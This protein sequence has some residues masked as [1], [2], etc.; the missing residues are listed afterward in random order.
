MRNA[1]SGNVPKKL[2]KRP[3][4]SSRLKNSNASVRRRTP[5]RR[6][7]SNALRRFVRSRLLPKHNAAPNNNVLRRP[8][9]ANRLNK[10]LKKRSGAPRSKKHNKRLSSV[11]K[12]NR[13]LR[14][15]SV[16]LKSRNW[17]RLASVKHSRRSKL[18]RPRNK[19]NAECLISRRVRND[20]QV[21]SH[22][23]QQR[24]TPVEFD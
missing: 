4:H 21:S 5:R 14:R 10:L 13:R 16:G 24:R 9:N 8:S 18:N 6:P 15:L 7:L 17:R 12:R 2:G 22:A 11:S 20:R 3:L 23:T 1:S 19:K